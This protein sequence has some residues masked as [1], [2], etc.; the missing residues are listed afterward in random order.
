MEPPTMP[1]ARSVR[2]ALG[3][4]PS[5]RLAR[6]VAEDTTSGVANRGSLVRMAGQVVMITGKLMRNARALRAGFMKFLPMPPYSCLTTM[7]AKASPMRTIHMGED[8]GRQ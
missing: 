8:T 4:S 6:G 5:F 2:E 1:R 7:M 3:I